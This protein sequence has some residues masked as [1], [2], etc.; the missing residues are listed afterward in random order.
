MR[1]QI[2]LFEHLRRIKNSSALTILC[3]DNAEESVRWT[4]LYYGGGT[5][6]V[7][8]VVRSCKLKSKAPLTL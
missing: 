8:Y 3:E 1:A 6:F 7:T 2:R 5:R 4:V